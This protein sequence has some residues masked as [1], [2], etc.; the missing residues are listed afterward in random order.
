MMNPQRLK[1]YVGLIEGLLSCPRGEEWILLRQN[2]ELVDRGLIEVM[3]QIANH[4]NAEGDFKAATYLH[5]WAGKL[6]HILTA[7]I[8]DDRTD[9]KTNAYVELIQAL[10]SCPKGTEPEVLTK[11][12]QLIDP[13][14]VRIMQEVADRLE[15]KG[16]LETAIYLRNLAADLNRTWLDEHKFEPTFKKELAPDPWFEDDSDSS[17]G[18]ASDRA[19]DSPITSSNDGLE[20]LETKPVASSSQTQSN[21]ESQLA[22]QLEAIAKILPQLATALSSKQQSPNPL[23]YMDVLERAIAN[24]WILSTD[25]V[26][27]LIGVKPHCEHDVNVYYRGSWIFSKAGKVGAQLGWKVSKKVD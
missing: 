14:L 22:R 19:N 12:E 17:D 4:F 9:D 10:L 23:W 3:E 21:P 6:H 24:N 18:V 8:E 11:Y 5:N 1:A 13:K 27:K 2:P 26:E 25:E 15:T 20:R 7:K 16:D